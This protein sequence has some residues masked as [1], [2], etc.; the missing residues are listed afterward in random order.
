[1]FRYS[2][3]LSLLVLA[4]GAV[5]S[6]IAVD[7]TPKVTIAIASKFN[8]TGPVNIVAADRARIAHLKNK[9]GSGAKRAS[10]SFDITNTA[11]TYTTGVAIGSPATTYTLLI[12]TGS[13]NT[14]VGA[15]KSYTATSTSKSTGHRVSVTYGSGSFSGTEYTDRVSLSSDLTINSQSI[16]VASSSSG[17]GSGIDGILGIGPVALTEGTV[18]GVSSVPT[19]TDNLYSQGTISTEAIGVYF[20]PTTS[21][22]TTNGELTFGGADSSKYTGSLKYTSLTS[23]SPASEYWGIDQSITYNGQTIL[24]STAGIV[25]TGTT[26]VYIAS[27]AYNKYVKATGAS[28]DSSTGL[29]KIS[30][31]QYNNLKT[32]NFNIGGTAYG[33]TANAQ[34]WPRS[35]NTYIGGSSNSIYLIVNDIGTNSGEGLDFIDGYTFLERFYTVYDTTNSRFGIATT[36]YTS[37]TSN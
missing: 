24:S 10:Y 18:S 2:A 11:V 17:F 31:S 21:R 20:A 13:S 1:M 16:G 28:L 23:T 7:N 12:D 8:S 3:L 4:I 25:D 22:S 5:A 26:L 19:V 29:L 35:L 37:A 15:D 34:I 6:P 14:W 36:Q 33:L 27:D 9:A 30:S 32:L